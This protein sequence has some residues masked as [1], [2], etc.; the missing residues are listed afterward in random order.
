MPEEALSGIRV[1]DFGQYIAGPFAAM[2]LAE[3]G[4]DVIKVERP[5][6]DP[7]RKEDGFLVWNRS[8]KS[9][10]LDLKK[11]EGLKIALELVKNADVLIE[12][13]R[14]GVMDR[15]GLGYE[16]VKAINHRIIYCSIS[17][18]VQPVRTRPF[19]ATSKL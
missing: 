18:S 14:P 10:I 9:I 7:A 11:S 12:N 16:A 2:L 19:R 8:K 15:L 4:A 1:I 13:Y 3:Q 6:G 5:R 17:A